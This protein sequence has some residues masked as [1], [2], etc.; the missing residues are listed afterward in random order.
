MGRLP[1]S[2]VKVIPRALNFT[3]QALKVFL[4]L[5]GCVASLPHR[6]QRHYP[7]YGYNQYN[8][9][10]GYAV[11]NGY[12]RYNGYFGHSGYNGY[13]GYRKPFTA[14]NK[15]QK[16]ST[17][18]QNTVFFRLGEVNADKYANQLL[19]SPMTSDNRVTAANDLTSPTA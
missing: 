19:S 14:F 9:H 16:L 12:N 8:G 18:N 2:F 5:V 15:D 10:I 13:N 6:F 4:L 7:R 17:G 3:I 1:D 11:N